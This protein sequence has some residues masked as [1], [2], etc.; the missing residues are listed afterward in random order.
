[1]QYQQIVHG[2]FRSRPNRFL[3]KV[4]IGGTEE[5]VH[6]KNTGRC[7]ELLVPGARVIL[8]D[9]PHA[10]EQGRKTRYS[11]VGVY[12]NRGE[13]CPPLLVNMDSQAPNLAAR[14]WLEGG[15]F[16][17][18]TGRCPREIRREVT[19]GQ[20]R[21]DLA[22]LSDGQPAFMEVK[23]VTLEEDGIAM[24]PDAPTERGVKHLL[25]LADAAKQGYQTYVLFVIQ[26]KEIHGFRA[27]RKTHET[28][29]QTLRQI[30]SAGVQVMA[31]D[32]SVWESGFQ[33]DQKIPILWD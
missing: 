18:A 1:M 16:E 15:G 32:C 17:A 14:E 2:I 22:F 27:N 10:R 25:E 6:V 8:E 4:E 5:T 23:G 3:A 29:A 33:V 11:L 12:K 19:Y 9:H 26:M 28:F 24:F 13:G 20:S 21:F 30:H 31:Y 7:R